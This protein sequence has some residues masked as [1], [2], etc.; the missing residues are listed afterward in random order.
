MNVN[1]SELAE[2]MRPYVIDLIDSVQITGSPSP[3]NLDGIHHAGSIGD[4]QAPQFLK[5]DGTRDLV[6]NLTVANLITIDGVD[7]SVHAGSPNAHHN[8][9]H[10]ISGADHS[11]T[12][13]HG[14]LS[15]VTADQHHNK[16]H[17]IVT[18]A[19]HTVTGAAMDIVGLTGVNTLGILT[20][21]AAPG[22]TSQ[23]LKT[24]GSGF[25]QLNSLEIAG[26][27]ALLDKVDGN[28]IPFYTD[29]YDIGSSTLLW[30]KGYLSELD[31]VIFSQLTATLIGGWLI[32]GK[33]E[34]SVNAD[35]GTGDT[36]VD[37]GQ[38][39]TNGHFV[40]FRTALEVEYMQVGTLVS[41]TR[42]NVTRNLDGS[43]ANAWPE[44]SVYL[45]LGTTG[46][47]RIELNSYDTPRIQIVEQGAT[48]NAQTERIRIGDLNGNWGY[49][50]PIFGAAFGE[51]A[52]N[53]PNITIE[54]TNGLRIRNY[55]TDIFK[56]DTSGT[57]SIAG[58]LNIG[59]SGGIYQ[60]TGTFGSPT[61]GL[62]MWN[63]SG[64]GRIG[65]YNSGTLQWHGSTDGKLYAGGGNIYMD[66]DGFSVAEGTSFTDPTSLKWKK[67]SNVQARLSANSP[68]DSNNNNFVSLKSNSG[69]SGSGTRL[70]SVIIDAEAFDATPTVIAATYL[71]VSAQPGTPD[72]LKV[73]IS[74]NTGS[75]LLDL[76]GGMS[77][78]DS[79]FTQAQ[80]YGVI[81]AQAFN[82]G[83]LPFITYAPGSR[84][85]SAVTSDGIV[86]TC[87]VPYA[88]LVKYFKVALLVTTT[89]D[90]SHYW[91]LNLKR[92][93]G[94][95][96][97]SVNTSAISPNTWSLRSATGVDYTLATSHIAL[98]VEAI[99]TGSPGTLQIAGPAV[100][101]Q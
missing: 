58:V 32:I 76:I 33:N 61:T 43:G 5:T 63:D 86:F 62:K 65:G 10:A 75:V 46:D 85:P 83:W 91:T 60:G 26:R 51:Y 11:G 71:T 78:H 95:S 80:D 57:A 28:L 89:N 53:K 41:G 30:R 21:N 45:V 13:G 92:I 59:S 79:T 17:G 47:G 70:S 97:S 27:L 38:S 7:V 81:R 73:S 42:Y 68:N 8:Q 22:T 100:Y 44:G 99:K 36:S 74:G 52:S 56:F 16:Q 54:P 77:V 94:T 69:F 20:P 6:G 40:V 49:A 98:Y 12:L 87:A 37:F 39:M 82:S 101:V 1:L 19:D 84:P 23:I 90:G 15:G 93:D 3:H 48:Y 55:S 18:A 34:G 50:S 64:V 14:A 66:S 25:L 72:D 24:D 31:T 29:T 9:V 4:S 67:G 96:V 88:C 35:V 2:R